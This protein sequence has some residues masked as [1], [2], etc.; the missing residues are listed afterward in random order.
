MWS[1]TDEARTLVLTVGIFV[2]RIHPGSQALWLIPVIPALWEVEVGRSQGQE[3]ET[4]LANEFETSLANMVKP[5]CANNT[6]ISQAWWHTPAISATREAEAKE[7]FELGTQRLRPFE[8]I[9]L[10]T[11]FAN[12]VALA[13]YIPF[14]EDDSNATNSNLVLLMHSRFTAAIGD[15]TSLQHIIYNI[16]AITLVYQELLPGRLGNQMIKSITVVCK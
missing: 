16:A 8:I 14:P 1:G 10:L 12:C 5:V 11:I 4:I 7:L 15:A 3:F 2:I 13:I 9:I 6:K